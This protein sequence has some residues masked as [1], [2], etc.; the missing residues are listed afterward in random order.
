MNRLPRRLFTARSSSSPVRD[1]FR[2][3]LN[4]A[5]ILFFSHLFWEHFY[6]VGASTGTSMLPTINASGDYILISKLHSRGRGVAPGDM[7]SYVHP[8]D[9]PGVHV[10]KRVVGM[11][12]DFVVMD[13]MAGTGDMVQV[14]QGHC[15]TAGDNLPCSKDSRYYGPV[16]LGLL[17]GKVIA[18]IWPDTKF[19]ENEMVPVVEDPEY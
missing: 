14:P 8:E 12:G 2:R 16:P 11:P 19:F 6:C 17:R 5:Q 4:A 9:G 1:A 18:R 3:I 10:C 13:P 15:W 7:V